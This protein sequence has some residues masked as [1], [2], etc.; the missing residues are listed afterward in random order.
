[1][2][3]AGPADPPSRP[4]PGTV[5]MLC[6]CRATTIRCSISRPCRSGLPA[7][8]I[9]ARGAGMPQVRHLADR[10]LSRRDRRSAKPSG[11]TRARVGPSPLDR[12]EV[13]ALGAV[14]TAAV[15][16][17]GPATRSTEDGQ[18]RPRRTLFRRR[19]PDPARRP[20]AAADSG[21]TAGD[22]DVRWPGGDGRI[23]LRQAGF[24]P[25]TVGTSGTGRRGERDSVPSSRLNSTTRSC[26]S[27]AA[28]STPVPGAAS[29]RLRWRRG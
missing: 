11:S 18:T 23:G 27:S 1:M 4:G 8:P 7:A 21:G 15:L 6:G 28:G 20:L 14:A 10:S 25:D 22:R 19:A 13:A 3:G 5:R 16:V 24:G 12:T 9:S 2:P 26:R 29:G 17:R